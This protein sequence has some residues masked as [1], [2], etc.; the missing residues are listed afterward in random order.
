MGNELGDAAHVDGRDRRLCGLRRAYQS[1]RYP[2]SRCLGSTAARR[3]SSSPRFNWLFI[4]AGF[5]DAW[6]KRVQFPL[7]VSRVALAGA[8]PCRVP[9]SREVACKLPGEMRTHAIREC[10]ATCV[11]S[12]LTFSPVSSL[13][14]DFRCDDT[15]RGSVVPSIGT[16]HWRAPIGYRVAE[17]GSRWRSARGNGGRRAIAG[18]LAVPVTWAKS[19]IAHHCRHRPVPVEIRSH[20]SADGPGLASPH[21]LDATGDTLLRF[22]V[23]PPRGLT[24]ADLQAT[25]YR[26]MLSG[27]GR[28]A[29]RAFRGR[30]AYIW[31]RKRIKLG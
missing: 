22:K 31:A 28:G 5:L 18:G 13:T 2:W 27:R 9:G 24:L 15:K 19:A 16:A 4:L 20:I 14:S 26:P 1:G 25:S 23:M 29:T 6:G 11:V 3:S 12:D 17:E 10:I 7:G 8:V 21:V 30:R